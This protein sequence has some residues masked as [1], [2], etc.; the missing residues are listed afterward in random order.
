VPPFVLLP[1]GARHL[2]TRQPSIATDGFMPSPSHRHKQVAAIL[3][4][5]QGSISQLDLHVARKVTVSHCTARSAGL[6]TPTSQR[7]RE[8]HGPNR[9]LVPS[10]WKSNAL[11]LSS[12]RTCGVQV[13]A[14]GERVVL[15]IVGCPGRRHG[16]LGHRRRAIIGRRRWQ[17]VFAARLG[18]DRNAARVFGHFR[19]WGGFVSLEVCGMMA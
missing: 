4:K 19:G 11:A 1:T 15:H 16:Y 3:G 8:A 9:A 5:G 18:F 6:K 17:L 13:G 14:V 2:V 10:L 7:F 12:Y